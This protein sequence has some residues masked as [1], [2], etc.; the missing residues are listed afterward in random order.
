MKTINTLVSSV[1][2]PVVDTN[3]DISEN[4]SSP[5]D[6]SSALMFGKILTG[7]YLFSMFNL[8]IMLHMSLGEY[9]S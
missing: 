2:Q 7:S 8:T 1:K 9:E 3:G 5:E 6:E 4:F